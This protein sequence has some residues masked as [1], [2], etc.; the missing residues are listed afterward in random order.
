MEVTGFLDYREY[1]KSELNNRVERNSSYSLRSFADQIGVSPSHLSRV[2]NGEKKLSLTSASRISQRLKHGRRQGS[3]FIDLIQLEL[4]TDLEV[5]AKLV[6]R[7]ST[8]VGEKNQRIVSLEQFK[9][10]SK[11]YH[12]VILTLTKLKTFQHDTNWIAKKLGVTKLTA[13]LAVDRLISLKLLKVDSNKRFIVCDDGQ[14][15]TTDDFSSEAIRINH[16][17]N[18]QRALEALDKQDV[19]DREFDNCSLSLRKKDLPVA[20]KMIREMMDK[21]NE[22]LDSDEGD[23]VYQ[24]NMQ[25]FRATHKEELQ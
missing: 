3:H 16:Q 13:K 21:L 4:A 24:L 2:L 12:F 15:S 9:L 11:W 14:I 17:Q 6:D 19:L 22:E 5:K 25:F 8:N 23:E 7:I 1:L 20:K 10:I 18:I